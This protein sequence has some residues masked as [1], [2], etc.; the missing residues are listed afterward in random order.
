MGFF[1]QEYWSGLP[2]P[3]PGDL[4]DPGIKPRFPTFQAD[5]LPSEPPGK[6]ELVLLELRICQARRKEEEKR[7]GKEIGGLCKGYKWKLGREESK[8]TR[9]RVGD[10][11]GV[12]VNAF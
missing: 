5:S 4:P 6:P 3:S 12:R 1:R 2:F 8:D 9:R 10:E 7:E 11:R